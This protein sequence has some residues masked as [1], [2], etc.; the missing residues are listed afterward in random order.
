MFDIF[1]IRKEH[2]LA[3]K[4]SP[5][6]FAQLTPQ[7][8]RENGRISCCWWKRCRQGGWPDTIRGRPLEAALYTW[9]PAASSH[10][11]L[12]PMLPSKL[13]WLT[14]TPQSIQPQPKRIMKSRNAL[15]SGTMLRMTDQKLSQKLPELFFLLASL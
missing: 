4:L 9:Q 10:S 8:W 11:L 1:K 15:F 12:P 14:G 13:F 6:A 7:T 2:E 3:D 5:S